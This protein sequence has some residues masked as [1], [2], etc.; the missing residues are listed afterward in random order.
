MAAAAPLALLPAAEEILQA[1][2][3]DLVVI[4]T[5]WYRKRKIGRQTVLEPIDIQFHVNPVSIAI[6]GAVGAVGLLAAVIAWNGIQLPFGTALPGIGDSKYW[7]D[8]VGKVTKGKAG[9]PPAPS[10]VESSISGFA[11]SLVR[12]LHL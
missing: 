12:L 6:G 3:N 5:K 4:D 1:V 11:E 9:N 2:N 7:R 8:V 10:S